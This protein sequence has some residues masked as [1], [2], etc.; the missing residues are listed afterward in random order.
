MKYYIK[1]GQESFYNILMENVVENSDEICFTFCKQNK[2]KDI[3][4]TRSELLEK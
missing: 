1:S 4:L 3:K 2:E